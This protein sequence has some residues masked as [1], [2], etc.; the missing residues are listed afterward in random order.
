MRTRRW[1]SSSRVDGPA[2]RGQER[3]GNRSAPAER[4]TGALGDPVLQV[5]HRGV[6]ER[7]RYEAQDVDAVTGFGQRR[8]QRSHRV[9]TAVTERVRGAVDDQRQFRLV[10]VT[11][12]PDVPILEPDGAVGM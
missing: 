2:H 8:R 9:G 6:P 12:V 10:S 11:G 1:R 7:L 4:P 3:L 5:G